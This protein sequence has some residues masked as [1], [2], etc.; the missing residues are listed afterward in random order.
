M[1][2]ICSMSVSLIIDERL[3][4]LV[5]CHHHA[6]R[7]VPLRLRSACDFIVQVAASQI[8][9]QQNGLRLRRAL[10]LHAACKPA[11]SPPWQRRTAIWTG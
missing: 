4:G 11:F 1:G 9:S 7:Y 8:E 2:T 5:S 3:W 10:S 6:P